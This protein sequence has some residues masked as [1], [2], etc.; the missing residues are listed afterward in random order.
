M[1]IFPNS[2]STAQKDFWRICSNAGTSN[3]V[4]ELVKRFKDNIFVSI[5]L[6]SK[7]GLYDV[8]TMSDVKE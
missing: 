8:T 3:G 1:R 5:K 4:I 7:R 2:P 6:D